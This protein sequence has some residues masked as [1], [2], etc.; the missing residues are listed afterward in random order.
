M[1]IKV[2]ICDDSALMRAMLTEIVNAA[3]DMQ[4][5]GTAADAFEARERIKALSPDVLTLDVEMPRMNGLEFL[6]RLMRLRPMPVVMISSFTREGSDTTLRALELG[7]VDFLAK[8]R[9]DPEKGLEIH[10]YDIR[11]KIRAASQATVRRLTGPV[12]LSAAGGGG[13]GASSSDRP[14]ELAA[15]TGRLASERLIAIGA[16]T[17]GTEAIREV[18]TALPAQTPPIVLVQHM[19]EMF[20][21][22]FAKRLDSLCRIQVKEAENGEKILPN[23]AYL[24]PGH[25][26]L[27]VRRGPGGLV[28]VLSDG[29][30]VNRHRPAVDVLFHSVAKEVGA[31][32]LGVI[33]TGMGKDGAQGMLAM[34]EAGAWTIA[35]DQESCV[36]YGMPREAANIG[37]AMEVAPLKEVA[38]RLWRRLL[39]S[40][41]RRLA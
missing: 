26:H 32:A 16:S 27:L 1:A 4:V 34:R 18:L 17:G 9:L 35:Q 28:C 39:A 31:N 2:L 8:P 13:K 24:A 7:A 12:A 29:E 33:L 21:G 3:P 37:A 36:V 22:S 14:G 5:V 23:T 15:A 25:S 41:E 11:E 10:G 38:G 40:G 6:D 20:T 30:P 19:P